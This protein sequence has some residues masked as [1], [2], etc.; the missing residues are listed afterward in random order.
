MQ[1]QAWLAGGVVL[2]AYLLAA[3]TLGWA[4][5]HHEISLATMLP[6]LPSSMA[7][8]SITYGN[9]SLE[10]QLRSL[11]DLD[12]LTTSLDALGER[13]PTGHR[14]TGLP[15]RSVRL[16]Q[17]GFTYPGGDAPVLNGV[18][19][20]LDVGTSLGLVGT[21][22]AGKTTPITLAGAAARAR[23]WPDPGRRRRAR[24]ARRTRV[25]APGR[26]RLPGLRADAAERRRERGHAQPRGP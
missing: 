24:R 25:A 14:A 4:A 6:M 2:V 8:G 3:G 21:N 10:Q 1:R 7:V 19:L 17:L 11:P 18:D 16:E 22:G 26:R 12:G 20:E 13:N 23:R 5:D 15:H 9:I